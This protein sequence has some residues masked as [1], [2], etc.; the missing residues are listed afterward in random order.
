[1]GDAD[2]LLFERL[3]QRRG[4]IETTKYEIEKMSNSEKLIYEAQ[5]FFLKE[6]NLLIENYSDPD[7]KYRIIKSLLDDFLE[8]F[9]VMYIETDDI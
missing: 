4:Y 8:D 5:L 9:S 6:L 1:M 7:K 2:R 3:I